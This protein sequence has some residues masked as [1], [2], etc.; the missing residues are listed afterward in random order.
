MT[1]FRKLRRQSGKSVSEICEILKISKT[2]LMNIELRDSIPNEDLLERME[3]LF[4][5]T[6]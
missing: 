6:T 2:D 1:D 4:G 5:V 3:N